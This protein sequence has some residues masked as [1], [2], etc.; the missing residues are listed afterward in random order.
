MELPPRSDDHV[1]FALFVKKPSDFTPGA[2]AQ[3]TGLDPADIGLI[4]I[5]SDRIVIDVHKACQQAAR[6]ALVE[7]GGLQTPAR[8]P[9]GRAQF[10]LLL[11][12]RSELGIHDEAAQGAGILLA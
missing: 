11:A 9:Q 1:R 2:V 5:E 10:Q 3:L 8:S 12:L 6:A 4:L 7:H